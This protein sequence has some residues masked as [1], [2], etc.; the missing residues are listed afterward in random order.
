MQ[1]RTGFLIFL[2]IAGIISLATAPHNASAALLGVNKVSLQYNDVLRNGYAEN[3]VIVSSATEHNISVY[4]E[5]RGDIKDWV[6]FE[7]AGQPVFVNKDHPQKI[8]IIVEPPADT[9]VDNYNGTIVLSTGPL[10]DVKGNVGANVVVAFELK[11]NVN[12]TDTQIL[13]CTAGGFN[14]KDAEIQK[15]IPF[16]ATIS[17]NGNVR[18]KPEF[19]FRIYDAN[20]TKLIK[21]IRTTYPQEFLPTTQNTINSQL[22]NDLEP[23]QYWVYASVPAC[24][25]SESLVTFSVLEKGGISDSGEL[26]RIENNAWALTNETI[27]IKAYFKN[28]GDRTVT[29]Q[30]KGVISKDGKIVQI[31]NSDKI[32]VAPGQSTPIEMFYQPDFTGQYKITGRVYYNNKLTFEKGS[33]LNVN[34]N[35]APEQKPTDYSSWILVAIIIILGVLIGLIIRKLKRRKRRAPKRKYLKHRKTNKY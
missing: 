32:D 14:I 2:I 4:Y 16:T 31:L 9:R 35:G 10:G 18:I 26:I 5:A 1:R 6:R 19:L 3:S 24:S 22:T 28:N 13:S 8:K 30:F 27:P 21:E 7:P 12:I 33:V 23:G 29:A 34:T 17:N 15:N 11:V 25:G 20:Q